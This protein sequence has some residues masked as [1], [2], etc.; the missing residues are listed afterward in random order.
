MHIAVLL[1]GRILNYREHH[2]NIIESIGSQHIIDFFYAS[3]SESDYDVSEFCE[4][5]KPILCKNEMI[6]YPVDFSV[7]LGDRPRETSI[8]NMTCHFINKER[9]FALLEQ[10]VEQTGSKYDC[11]LSTRVDIKYHESLYFERFINT[12]HSV[13]FIPDSCD[14]HGINDQIAIGNFTS[15]KKYMN[16]YSNTVP[17]LERGTRIT[18]ECLF[19]AH[20][21]DCGLNVCRFPLSYGIY[22]PILPWFP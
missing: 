20:I 3:D 13:I 17:L 12:D 9:V 5:Y 22:H 16:I 6:H 19:K 18:G 21:E 14:A 2:S 8:H 10:H 1:Y 7:F 4:L 11:I 15:M